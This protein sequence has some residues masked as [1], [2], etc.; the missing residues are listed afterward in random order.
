[1]ERALRVI[2]VERGYDPRTFTLVAFGGAGGLHAAALA[3]A[4]GMP[5]CSCRG[6]RAALGVG[7][8]RRRGRA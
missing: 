7:H 4:L 8:A 2:S 6:I 5:A 3:D 1:M